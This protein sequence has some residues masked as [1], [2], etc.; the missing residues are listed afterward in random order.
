MRLAP[1]RFQ[2]LVQALLVALQL[3]HQAPAFF[4]FISTRQ[5]RQAC[6]Q[7]LLRLLDALGL[8]I[9][10]AH[11]HQLL[12]AARLQGPDLPEPPTASRNTRGAKQQ[13]KDRQAVAT[14]RRSDRVST[15]ASSA[16]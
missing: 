1:G 11:L 12:L 6:G 4:Q 15:G 3:R 8:F 5:L 14:A 10:G 16:G 13:S 9:Q 7:L 2:T